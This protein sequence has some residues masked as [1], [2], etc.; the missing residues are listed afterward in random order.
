MR[1]VSRP[2]SVTTGSTT[3]S[4]F[5]MVLTTSSASSSTF[6]LTTSSSQMCLMS[7]RVL[8]AE[9]SSCLSGRMPSRRSSL[10]TTYTV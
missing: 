9:K 4:Y 8:S 10:S 5:F 7:V 3:T 6:T 2:S 1:P